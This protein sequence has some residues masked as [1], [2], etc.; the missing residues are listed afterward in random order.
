VLRGDLATARAERG[1]AAVHA[2]Q[3]AA[4]VSALTAALAPVRHPGV[5][6]DRYR[7]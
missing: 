5:E 4:Q 6:E 3:L 1:A 2:E 7:S